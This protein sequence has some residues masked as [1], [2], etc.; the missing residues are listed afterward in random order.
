MK[1]SHTLAFN[2][3][4]LSVISCLVRFCYDT[5]YYSFL[6]WEEVGNEPDIS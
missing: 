5:I 1:R 6:A 3:P 2:I 4:F